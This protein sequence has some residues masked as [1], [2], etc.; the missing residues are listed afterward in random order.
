[1]LKS[2]AHDL[3]G[4]HEGVT[5]VQADE[6]WHVGLGVQALGDLGSDTAELDDAVDLA[7]RAWPGVAIDRA[8]HDRRRTILARMD[9]ARV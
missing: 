1:M 3:P 5:R 8:V 6:R 7:A 2:A 9:A 4:L